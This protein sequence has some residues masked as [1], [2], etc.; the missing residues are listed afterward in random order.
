MPNTTVKDHFILSVI[1]I[2]S[3]CL[4]GF[5]SIP[6]AITALIFSLRIQD[7][8]RENRQEEAQKL[9]TWA[10]VFAWITILIALIPIMLFI[11]FGGAILAFF[12]ALISALIAAA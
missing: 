12:T 8:V 4:T 6:I 9:S 1:A 3:S 5:F 2:I 11:L 7:L 10:A